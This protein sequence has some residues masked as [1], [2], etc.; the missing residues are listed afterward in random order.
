MTIAL[1]PPGKFLIFVP[2]LRIGKFQMK[3]ARIN[4]AARNEMPASAMVSD[5]CS[6]MGAP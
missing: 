4:C 1:A 5:I 3:I 6:S 2:G